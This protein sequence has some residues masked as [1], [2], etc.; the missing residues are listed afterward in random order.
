MI[1]LTPDERESI[2]EF[3]ISELKKDSKMADKLDEQAEVLLP[4]A[5]N[6]DWN[7]QLKLLKVRMFKLAYAMKGD[8]AVP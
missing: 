6:E 5:G 2:N 1:L 3:F 4:C 8:K 7:L